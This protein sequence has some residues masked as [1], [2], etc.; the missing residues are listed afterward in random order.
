MRLLH[1]S[2]KNAARE[3]ES[4]L[5]V[6]N[7]PARLSTSARV[8]RLY[9]LC[10]Q[11]ELGF[12][13]LKTPRNG[14]SFRENLGS[15]RERVGVLMLLAALATYVLWLNGL[16]A[17]ARGLTRTFQANTERRRSVLSVCQLGRGTIRRAL[18]FT[19]QERHDAAERIRERVALDAT[20][21][22]E[23]A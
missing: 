3:R 1:E 5:L 7:L 13:D 12:R 8:V 6:S 20:L 11:I 4:W 19:D 21:V 10:M 2:E 16:A 14:F 22:P 18:E 17:Q 15:H 9:R 23:S